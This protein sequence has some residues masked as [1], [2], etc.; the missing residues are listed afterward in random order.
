M[1]CLVAVA[2]A[3]GVW[4][5]ADSMICNAGERRLVVDRKLSRVTD[6][7]LIGGSGLFQQVQR[8]LYMLQVPPHPVGCDD[9]RYLHTLLADA[10]MQAVRQGL[11][12]L[13]GHRVEDPQTAAVFLGAYR[14][15]IF[16]VDAYGSVTTPLVPY[17]ACGSG[18]KVAL[19][20]LYASQDQPAELRARQALA[21]AAEHCTDVAGPM[22]LEFQHARSAVVL[23]RSA[24]TSLGLQ[25]PGARLV[26]PPAEADELVQANRATRAADAQAATHGATTD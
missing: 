10:L 2:D 17:A 19:G 4:M 3:M 5:G 9:D 20:A 15:R 7:L 16:L 14:G 25:L 8:P 18:A 12:D 13:Y 23:T 1:T 26:L 6:E 24:H 22:V 21:A 11:P